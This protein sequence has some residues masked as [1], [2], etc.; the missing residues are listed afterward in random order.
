MGPS[1]LEAVRQYR[2][3][4]SEGCLEDPVVQICK[5]GWPL[6][7]PLQRQMLSKKHGKR[8]VAKAHRTAWQTRP[9]AKAR[10]QVAAKKSLENQASGQNTSSPVVARLAT[11]PI[12]TA[13]RRWQQ[14]L[15]VPLPLQPVGQIHVAAKGKVHLPKFYPDMETP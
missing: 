8:L 2:I 12:I 7:R 14:G 10:R 4:F 3:F 1:K 13:R 5:T 15:G 9:V 6:T 11:I